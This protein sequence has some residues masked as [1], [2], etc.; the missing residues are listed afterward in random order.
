M[1]MK[2]RANGVVSLQ[3]HGQGQG[4]EGAL[5]IETLVT[6]QYSTTPYGC[7]VKHSPYGH[8]AA[9][10]VRYSRVGDIHIPHCD[11]VAPCPI[12]QLFIH[13]SLIRSIY[14]KTLTF[15]DVR[16]V[17]SFSSMRADCDSLSTSL[18]GSRIRCPQPHA[19]CARRA[20]CLD[21]VSS[22]HAQRF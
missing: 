3:G 14:S 15:V 17:V 4:R 7:G 22:A 19:M 8:G 16:T 11:L 18:P 10:C 6:T 1:S 9:R 5:I 20:R 12:H 2:W 13:V 21:H